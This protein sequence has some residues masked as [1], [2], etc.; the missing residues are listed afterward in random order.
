MLQVL[1][2]MT[3]GQSP[4]VG[5]EK[6]Q[7]SAAPQLGEGC[8]QRSADLV[9]SYLHPP[10]CLL[11]QPPSVIVKNNFA[12]LVP[13]LALGS[14]AL[15]PRAPWG[16]PHISHPPAGPE[17]AARG[18]PGVVQWGWGAWG[19]SPLQAAEGPKAPNPDSNF[20]FIRIGFCPWEMGCRA[21][22]PVPQPAV[23]PG[24]SSGRCRVCGARGGSGVRRKGL[25]AGV[26]PLPF[27]L[28]ARLRERHAK[29][30]LRQSDPRPPHTPSKTTAPR[31]RRAPRGRGCRHSVQMCRESPSTKS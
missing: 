25:A 24:N 30:F 13:L 21:L 19:S 16:S 7:R 4:Q 26:T 17:T 3:K 2:A 6:D 22:S 12:C 28:R 1:G 9:S 29:T 20:F 31:P 23:G 11:C 5:E 27:V 18:A 8:G 10:P 15:C 14:S